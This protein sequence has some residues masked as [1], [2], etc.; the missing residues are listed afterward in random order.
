MYMIH[1]DI[2]ELLNMRLVHLLYYIQ[3]NNVMCERVP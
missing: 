3:N 1:N 2:Y